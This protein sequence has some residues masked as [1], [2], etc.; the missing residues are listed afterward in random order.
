[1]STILGDLDLPKPINISEKTFKQFQKYVSK[2]ENIF[3]HIGADFIQ[4][5][6]YLH[7]FKKYKSDCFLYNENDNFRLLGLGFFIKNNETEE[8]K[9]LREEHIDVIAKAFIDCIDKKIKIVIIPIVID[10]ED[11]DSHSN[12]LIYRSQHNE[13]EHFEPHGA[14][15]MLKKKEGNKIKKIIMTFV[16]HCNNL[17]K[18]INKEKIKFIPSNEVCPAIKGLQALEAESTLTNP[19][20][21][22]EAYCASWN[23]FF[24]E[25]CLKNPELKSSEIV[26]RLLKYFKNQDNIEDYLRKVIRGYNAI[27]GNKIESYLKILFGDE[28]T[29]DYINEITNEKEYLKIRRLL[30][31]LLK[32]ESYLLTDKDFDLNKEMKQIDIEI[33][34]NKF[35][36]HLS[37]EEKISLLAKK[38]ILENYEKIDQANKESL[39]ENSKIELL[40]SVLHNYGENEEEISSTIEDLKTIS[41]NRTSSDS[42]K[43]SSIVSILS[44]KSFQPNKRKG[45]SKNIVES[46]SESEYK[47]ESKKEKA[48]DE[49]NIQPYKKGKSKNVIETETESEYKSETKRTNEDEIIKFPSI[50]KTSS[51][52]KKSKPKTKTNVS[53]VDS[54]LKVRSKSQKMKSSK[55]TKSKTKTQKNK[56]SIR[57]K[58]TNRTIEEEKCK[59]GQIFSPKKWGCVNIKS[60]KK[61]PKTR[62][63][64]YSLDK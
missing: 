19:E 45:K 53:T 40:S 13:I 7:M 28:T 44:E 12:V 32:I 30:L 18:N 51:L 4:C 61:S 43:P 23:N 15:F 52:S 1:M 6:I 42:K 55:D 46:E 41:E 59:E 27:V 10:Q 54:I 35:L 58:S 37:N 9:K 2:G 34:K 20:D 48:T 56:P 33:R 8:D 21:I 22:E 47:S 16:N 62:I 17:L 25:V 14:Y 64:I 5:L 38:K 60:I 31:E 3:S 63:N 29:I 50:I 24:T 39:T 36:K 49:S 57:V 26:D 11:E